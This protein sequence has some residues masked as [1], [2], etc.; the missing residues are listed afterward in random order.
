METLPKAMLLLASVGQITV[1]EYGAISKAISSLTETWSSYN[2]LEDNLKE[3]AF[4][5][6]GRE[7]EKRK[8]VFYVFQGGIWEEINQFHK[9]T[10]QV[11]EHRT[12][13][14]RASFICGYC[15]NEK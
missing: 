8:E 5:V 6:R 14:K 1:I 11:L 3:G 13:Q 7:L 10:A 9:C 15:F 12:N 2:R 4:K